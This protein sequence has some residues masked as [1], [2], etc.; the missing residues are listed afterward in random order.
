MQDAWRGEAGTLWRDGYASYR[1]RQESE[2]IM[3]D[4]RFRFQK[5]VEAGKGKR[6]LAQHPGMA[7]MADELR[8]A[9]E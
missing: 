2:R 7:L 6:R 4:L 3:A 9:S 1:E 5:M 8:E